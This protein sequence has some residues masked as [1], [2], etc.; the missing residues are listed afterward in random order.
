M[1]TSVYLRTASV[2][3]LIHAIL[4][5]AGGVFGKPAPGTAA[6]V[7]ATMQANRF[8]VFGVT[9]SYAD[10]YLGLGLGITIFLLVAA[11]LMWQMAGLARTDAA[12]LRPMM[13]TL[14]VG[15]LA[16][17]VNSYLY[18]FLAPVIV[19]VLIALCLGLAM[20]AAKSV[21]A[22]SAAPA[23]QQSAR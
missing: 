18:F 17:A 11:V 22:V 19:E 16:F 8:R 5:T 10:F 4:H 20:M 1:K 13:A 6:M 12:R 14:M 3:T 15:F 9:R 23:A 7:V 21:P 2:L